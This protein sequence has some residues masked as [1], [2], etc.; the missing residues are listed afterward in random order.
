ML[1]EFIIIIIVS[2]DNIWL[3]R[4]EVEWCAFHLLR[5]IVMKWKGYEFNHKIMIKVQE[6]PPNIM[7]T[8][9]P[10]VCESLSYN[11]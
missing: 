9:I 4:G 11:T 6:S 8:R 10:I 7:V 5:G 2:Y 3:S 1:I